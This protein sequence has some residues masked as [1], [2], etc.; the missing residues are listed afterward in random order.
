MR[1]LITLLFL[2]FLVAFALGPVPTLAGPI[3]VPPS[4]H[5]GDDYRLIFVTSTTRDGNSSNVADYNNFV[6]N[7]ANASPSLA[8]LGTTWSAIASTATVAAKDNTGTNPSASLGYP[9]YTLG[10][11]LVA[12]DNHQLW[13]ASSATPLSTWIDITELGTSAAGSLVWTGTNPLGMPANPLGAGTG[14]AAGL[15]GG[16]TDDWTYIVISIRTNGDSPLVLPFYAIS[17][18]LTVPIPEPSSV[19]LA[20]FGFAGLAAWCWRR[21]RA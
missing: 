6:T 19:A 5:P 8:A 21:K 14:S 17:G 7:A 10:G 15:A 9:V 16:S 11:A 18:V 2:L 4:L 20:A 12:V 13:N 3:T 1:G